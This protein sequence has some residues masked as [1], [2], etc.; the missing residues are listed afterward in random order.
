MN[1]ELRMLAVLF[2]QITSTILIILIIWIWGDSES[3]KRLIN[4]LY[5]SP[6]LI[7]TLM[8]VFFFFLSAY[9]VYKTL[10]KRIKNKS[11]DKYDE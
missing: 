3:G 11:K 5:I 7:K 10:K 4:N 8:S 6:F 2:S 1:N 9:S